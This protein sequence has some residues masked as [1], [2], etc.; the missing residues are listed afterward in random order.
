MGR[1]SQGIVRSLFYTAGPNPARTVSLRFSGKGLDISQISGW[2][3]GYH[4]RIYVKLVL[5][6]AT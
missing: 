3:D 5:F 2:A 1:A 4:G 6:G